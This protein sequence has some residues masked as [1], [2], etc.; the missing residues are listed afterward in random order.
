RSDLHFAV[1][2]VN[3]HWSGTTGGE[4]TNDSAFNAVWWADVLGKLIYDGAYMVNYFDL[5]SSNARGGWGLLSSSGA[6]PSYYVYQL[7]QRFGAE[8]LSASSSEP[9]VSAYAARREDGLVS[10]IVTT[11]NDVA[12]EVPVDFAGPVA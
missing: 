5:Q 3:S 6:R 2:E 10:V 8:L 1:T 9:Y 12:L 11:L 7:Y 4:A